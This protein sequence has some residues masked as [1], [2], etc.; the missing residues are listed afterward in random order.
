MP[1][2]HQTVTRTFRLDSQA[3]EH[4]RLTDRKIA[5]VDH[6][7]H[8]AFAFGDDLSS[9]QGDELAELVLQ[10]AQCVAKFSHGFPAHRSRRYAPF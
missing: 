5:N 9:L 3:V 2:L 6:L 1:L 4:S 10:I 8:L 7:L